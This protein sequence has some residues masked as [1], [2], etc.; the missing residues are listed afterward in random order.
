LT[1]P[2]VTNGCKKEMVTMIHV[3][4]NILLVDDEKDFVEMLSM[5]LEDAG[6]KVTPAYDGQMCLEILEKEPIDVV[7]LDIKM[8]GMDGI[9]T[10]RKIKILIPLGR[11]DSADGAWNHGNRHRRNE[12]WR[13]RLPFETGRF[14]GIEKHSG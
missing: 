4:T 9:Q 14:R 13:F 11:S 10:L 2:Q 12:T 5:R 6:E 3:P 8:P 7:I 1:W